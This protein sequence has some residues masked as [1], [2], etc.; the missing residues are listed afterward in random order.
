MW[1]RLESSRWCTTT[2]P[3]IKRCLREYLQRCPDATKNVYTQF[4]DPLTKNLSVAL[5]HL[6][7]HRVVVGLQDK[8]QDKRHPRRL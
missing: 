3:R 7:K 1:Q 8:V 6:E 5:D 4:F 2:R